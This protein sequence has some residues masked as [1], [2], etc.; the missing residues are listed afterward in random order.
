MAGSQTKDA[1]PR[2]GPASATINLRLPASDKSLIDRAAEASGKTR[3]E[4]V[5]ETARARAIDVILDKTVFSLD[6]N[7]VEAFRAVLDNPPP[8]NA[9]LKALMARRAPWDE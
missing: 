7:A 4:F 6:E 3:T 1:Q 9:K 2:R 8:P 5:L